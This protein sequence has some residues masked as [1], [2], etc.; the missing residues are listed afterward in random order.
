MN[1]GFT[2]LF[3][4]IITSSLWSEDDK[5]RI[6]FITMLAACNPTGYVAGTIPGMA[7]LSRMTLEDAARSIERL[8]SPDEYSRSREHDGRRLVPCDCGGIVRPRKMYG[9]SGD[10]GRGCGPGSS[11]GGRTFKVIGVRL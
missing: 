3:G 4:T 1:A 11:K 6:M 2:K 8:C 9:E 10:H 5:T 7:A